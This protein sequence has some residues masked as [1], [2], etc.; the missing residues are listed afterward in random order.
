MGDKTFTAELLC[1]G[2]SI[3]KGVVKLHDQI[4]KSWKS[5]TINI[6]KMYDGLV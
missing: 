1:F 2:D 3:Y 4:Y 5:K 6:Y